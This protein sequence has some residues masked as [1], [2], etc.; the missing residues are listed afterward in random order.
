MDEKISMIE[1]YRNKIAL[2]IIDLIF[3][4]GSQID[5][6]TFNGYIVGKNTATG[7]Y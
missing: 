2:K 5:E 4:I 3:K 7:N 1:D 6:V